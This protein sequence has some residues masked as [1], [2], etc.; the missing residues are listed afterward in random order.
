MLIK[1]QALAQQLK[2]GLAPLYLLTGQDLYQLE[3]SAQAIKDCLRSQREVDSQKISLQSS[4]DWQ[5]LAEAANSYALFAEFSLIDCQFEKKSFDNTAK[6]WLG[7]YLQKPNPQTLILLRAY[8]VPSKNLQWLADHPAAVIVSAYPLDRGSLLQWIKTRLQQA[9]LEF[10][11]RLAEL[12]LMHNE[13]NHLACAQSI[14]KIIISTG[15]NKRIETEAALAHLSDQSQ[16]QLY[17]LSEACLNGHAGKA[18][19][20]CRHLLVNRNELPLVLWSLS[21]EIRLICQL[22]FCQQRGQ[23]FAAAAKEL[24]IWQQKTRSYQ[25]A[26]ARLSA[27]QCQN[28]LSRCSDIDQQF[29][30]GQAAQ[31]IESI[32][33]LVISLAT[34]AL[35]HDYQLS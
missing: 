27:S 32:E 11:T 15:S 14:E 20:I 5:T 33:Q 12:I 31:A 24:K 25:L 23:S 18:L 1:C 21:Q 8:E 16:F 6:Q 9:G 4:E 29:K 17:E 35:I 22:F 3:Q 30:T 7:D 28:L 10:E 13:G 34:G 26:M 19:Q 2:R